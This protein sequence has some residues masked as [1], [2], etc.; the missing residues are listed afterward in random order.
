MSIYE[1]FKF[2]IFCLQ[3]FI[4]HGLLTLCSLVLFGSIQLLVKIIDHQALTVRPC[5][6]RQAKVASAF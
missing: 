2:R 1:A 5:S 4:G 6:F 3:H